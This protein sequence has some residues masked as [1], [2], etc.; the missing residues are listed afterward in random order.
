MASNEEAHSFSFRD[1]FGG[2]TA[3]T[4]VPWKDEQHNHLMVYEEL[5]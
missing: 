1:R 5:D 2:E 4:L 3:P